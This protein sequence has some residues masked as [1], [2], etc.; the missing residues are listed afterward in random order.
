[1]V[2]Q[3]RPVPDSI[4]LLVGN[5][6]IIRDS[7]LFVDQKSPVAHSNITAKELSRLNTAQDV[8]YLLRFT[9]SLVST[10]DAGTGVGYTGL[11]IRGSDPSRINVTINNIPLNDAESQQVFWVNL[12]DLASST[13]DIQIQRGAGPSTA[14]P[15]A[16]GG[17][18]HINTIDQNLNLPSKISYAM[19]WGSFNSLRKTI[20]LDRIK[21]GKG[22]F[23][24]AR[25]SQVNS[26]GYIDRASALMNGYQFDLQKNTLHWK[27]LLTAFGGNERTYQSWY[28]TPHERL[29]G[30][31]TD[32][33]DFAWRNGLSEAETDNLI[34]S[35]RTYNYYTHPNQVDQYQQHHQQFHALYH[36]TK[37]K[38]HTTI[39]HTRGAGYFEEQKLGTALTNYNLPGFIPNVQDGILVDYADIIRRRWLNNNLMGLSSRLSCT[40]NEFNN[41]HAGIYS[42]QYLGHHFGEV[43]K[44]TP[45]P[46]YDFSNPYYQGNAQKS[47]QTFYTQ[48]FHQR[49]EWN[50][51]IDLQLRRVNYNT[52]GISNDLLGYNIHDDL[53]FFNPKAGA[54][55]RINRKNQISG[56][57]A[58]IGKE[59][60]RNDYIDNAQMPKPE[61]MLDNELSWT[62]RRLDV[63]NQL[64]FDHKGINPN[65]NKPQLRLSQ[66]SVNLFWMQYKDQLVLTGALNDVGAPLRTNIASSFRRGIEMEVTK[67]MTVFNKNLRFYANATISEHQ[68]KAFNEIIF[69][70]TNGF[71]MLLIEHKNS[72]IS[73]SPQAIASTVL[74]YNLIRNVQVQWQWK[75]VGLQHLDNTGNKDRTIP[76]Y[77]VQD[78]TLMYTKAN[79]NHEVQL[80][81]TLNNLLNRLYVTNGYT[82]GYIVGERIDERFYYPQ[83]GRMIWAGIKVAL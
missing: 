9:P 48:Y 14:G 10:S 35:G 24:N 19:Q 83:A 40:I 51:F 50:G 72:P 41:I 47:D 23:L 81:L 30:N 22:I 16:F 57:I 68:I 45:T 49:S 76:S 4:P 13:N 79:P 74:Q 5:T 6:L 82:Y 39:F 67:D 7:P 32:Q 80:S 65:G 20:Q 52:T 43:I 58:W 36:N 64:D 37:L 11:W 75:Y 77:Q 25:I 15:G 8:P 17:S 33:L 21:L 34:Q 61:Y 56:L 63:N 54:S 55:F 62:W 53:I 18:I 69:D 73:F 38:W 3:K 71:D 26:D 78:L 44:M 60:N 31:S 66:F 59:P 46:D 28:G 70:Y 2:P 27:F 12:P 29:Y 1:L 42:M